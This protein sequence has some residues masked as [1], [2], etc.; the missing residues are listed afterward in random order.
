MVRYLNLR[1]E[2]AK[3]RTKIGLKRLQL[4]AAT[5]ER[6]HLVFRQM[7]IREFIQEFLDGLVSCTK[8]GSHER[9][10]MVYARKY[11]LSLSNVVKDYKIKQIPYFLVFGDFREKFP[12]LNK[13]LISLDDKNAHEI[14]IGVD[15]MVMKMKRAYNQVDKKTKAVANREIK[16]SQ[17]VTHYIHRSQALVELIGGS[18]LLSL[19]EVLGS[20]AQRMLRKRTKE[21][22]RNRAL[23]RFYMHIKDQHKKRVELNLKLADD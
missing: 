11:G 5:N 4:K 17:Q 14:F 15:Q 20:L 13:L 16:Y 2:H 7:R 22:S 21:E 23:K 8:D 19:D 9:S 3:M 18:P 10:L 6:R 1:N 12:Q